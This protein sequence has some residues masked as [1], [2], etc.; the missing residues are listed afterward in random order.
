MTIPSLSGNWIDL[1]IIIFILSFLISSIDKGF[2]INFIDLTGFGVSFLSALKFYSLASK[3]LTANFSLPIGIANAIGFVI[4]GFFSETIFFLVAR[5]VY[6]RIP[7]EYINSK[8]NLILSPV[9]A[10]LNGLVIITFFLTVI[11][12]AP[13]QP[14][15]KK[16]LFDSK[17]GYPLISRTQVL[18]RQF[19]KLIGDA[20]LDTLSFL[21]V[22]PESSDKVD[23][24]FKTT[25]VSVDRDS[26]KIMLDLINKERQKE[27]LNTLVSDSKLQEVARAHAVDMFKNGYFSHINLQG[28]SPFDRL[29]KNNINF[30][31]A[32]ENLAFAPTVD[33]AHEG[34]MQSPGHRANILSSDYNRAGIGVI[35]GG[36]YGKMFVQEFT[37]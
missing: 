17:L 2:I 10:F 16:A 30:L 5:F 28:E 18:E 13:I 36:V 25:Q 27:S 32:G 29:K 33:L 23:L 12:A 26:E 7:K 14:R 15:I 20:V 11:S 9:P 24:Q 22:K 35:D 19:S 6:V 8:L 21:T 37:D 1:L 3:L 31:V 34:L 4:V